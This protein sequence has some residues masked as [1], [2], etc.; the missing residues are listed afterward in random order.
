MSGNPK[1]SWLHIS[2]LH[3]GMSGQD[4]LWSNVQQEFF[5]D[6][7]SMH[8]ISGPWHLLF[9][10]GDIVQ[11]GS[12][13]EF[14]RAQEN[15]NRLY[16]HLHELGSD[17]ILI[18]VPGNHDLKRPSDPGI[19]LLLDKFKSEKGYQDF[20]D[21][22]KSELRLVV[23]K[24]FSSYNSWVNNNP[25][26]HPHSVTRG[27]LPGDYAATVQLNDLSIGIVGLNSSF[28]QL[29]DD[30]REGSLEI[31]TKQLTAVCGDDYAAWAKAHTCCFLMT[32]HPPNWL[33]S[34]ASKML[35]RDIAPPSRFVAH[36]YGHMH[37]PRQMTVSIGGAD[38]ITSLQAP[39]LFGLEYFGEDKARQKRIH[40]YSVGEIEINATNSGVLRLWPR[41]ALE[42]QAGHWHFVQDPTATLLQDGATKGLRVSISY[43]L[44]TKSDEQNFRVLLLTTD[45]DLKDHRLRVA[46]HLRRSLGVTVDESP[47]AKMAYDVS[48][49]IQAWCWNQ[50]FAKQA[51]ER[52][53]ARSKAV[54]L[55]DDSADWPPRRLVEIAAD[56]DVRTF[57]ES[58]NNK[59]ILFNDPSQLPELVG[60]EIT[61]AMQTRIG[62]RTAGYSEWE[63]A[64]LEFRLPAWRSG[65]TTQGRPHLF[66]SEKAEELY[67]P[68]L[69]VSMD[70]AS[71]NWIRGKDNYPRTI[72]RSKAKKRSLDPTTARKRIR[73]A[74]WIC[75]PELA[76]IAFVGAPGGGKTIFLTRIAAA[77]AN[78][79]LGRPVVFEPDLNLDEIR[80]SSRV[81][82][83][84]VLEAT[85]ILDKNGTIDI[86]DLLA[87][88]VEEVCCAGANNTS[89]QEILEGVQQGRYL[90]LID[91]L[92]EIADS[93]HRLKVLTMLKGVAGVY[94]DSRFV[95]TTRSARYTG[96]LRFSPEFETVEV[97]GLDTEQVEHLCSNWSV[98]RQRDAKYKAGLIGATQSL[99]ERIP[100]TE[101][102]QNIIENPLMLTATC[103]VFERYR[104]LPDDRGRLC[105]LLVDDL[106]RS[107]RSED[108]ERGWKLDEAGKKDLLQR[109][110]LNMQSDGAQSWPLEKAIQIARQLV[111]SNDSA[112]ERR[113]T[114]YVD[115]AADHTGILRFQE[116]QGNTEQVRFWHRIFR[117]HLAATRIAQLD[118]TASSKIIDLWESGRLCNPFWEDV[119]R[120]LPRALGT[121]EKAKSVRE[122]L[123]RLADQE[124]N[125]RGR[126]HGLAIAGVIENR[127]LFPDVNFEEIANRM[128]NL[129]EMEGLS[130]PLG[131]R[132]MFLE[133][134]GRL[135]PT[136]GDPRVRREQWVELTA[137]RPSNRKS[138]TVLETSIAKYPV[139]VQEFDRFFSAED[140][141]D[142]SYWE[143]MPPSFSKSRETLGMRLQNQKRHPNHPMVWVGVGEAIAYCRWRTKHR[144]DGKIVRLPFTSEWQ[145]YYRSMT[146][147]YPWGNNPL[148]ESDAAQANWIGS[149]IGHSTP[150]GTFPLEFAGCSDV[151]GN[152]WEWCLATTALKVRSR[153]LPVG[154]VVTGGSFT[155]VPGNPVEQVIP[156]PP[157]FEQTGEMS[158]GFRCALSNLSMDVKSVKFARQI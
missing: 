134:L 121:I 81:P 85:K 67:H 101:E 27:I 117:E 147:K 99:T 34:R 63:R 15:L 5:E 148:E 114:K 82:I 103:M 32:H 7:K 44:P 105:E 25:F 158:I 54:L 31:S 68:E 113:A 76:R 102:E 136:G 140:F 106:C 150:I 152:T 146:T 6:L 22:S 90:L 55:V 143:Q 153:N 86:Q 18:C 108:V 70:G 39:S 133:S 19:S 72:P 1:I 74:K 14:I 141:N 115:W 87:S 33:S 109:I 30:N 58:V 45:P 11:R 104:S 154:F 8:E 49:L 57:R 51:W 10:S 20:W 123:E 126:L 100:G 110:A 61:T 73:L 53:A 132:I 131:D 157:I 151:T 97:C 139:T 125:N 77:L 52:T 46:E 129:Y 89:A 79:C 62:K 59:S 4:S 92:D 155:S 48:I 13:Q 21:N 120:L 35:T 42:H 142:P 56:A 107:R 71:Q 41:S 88:I 9:F 38:P 75:R 43:R 119:I 3:R 60:K 12:K 24:S 91:A 95:L 93:H 130:W 28:L 127:D 37:E 111:P 128:A 137:P 94:P 23:K 50:G 47:V 118:T 69:Y 98:Q 66:D 149:N 83:P 135:D 36:L 156:P 144:S 64:Y 78:F 40:G 138:D 17:P 96:D 16:E 80:K 29:T 26:I 65:R 112:P 124:P 2:D 122:E 145:T 116:A 84:I